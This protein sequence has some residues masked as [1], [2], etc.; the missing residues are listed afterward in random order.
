MQEQKKLRR[1]IAL[2]YGCLL[3]VGLAYYGWGALTG[4]YLPCLLNR[5]T[6]LLCPGCGVSRMFLSLT[7]ADVRAAFSYNPVVFVLLILWNLVALLCFWGRPAFLRRKAVLTG[8]LWA[9]VVALIIFGVVRN[10]P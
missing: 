1:T 4:K 9:T 8:G 10:L 6:G 7:R 3:A 5:A 2:V